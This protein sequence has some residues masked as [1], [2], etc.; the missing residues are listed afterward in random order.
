MAR[1]IAIRRL[2]EDYQ[3]VERDYYRKT[4]IFPPMHIIAIRRDVY[5]RNRWVAQSLCKAFI[6]AQ[7]EVYGE[8]HET[9]ALM[10]ML[11]WLTS[12]VEE[13]EKLMGRDFWPYGYEPNIHALQHLPSIS[14]RTGSFEAPV[15][16][17]GDFR[18][19]VAR[20][21]QDLTPKWWSLSRGDIDTALVQVGFNLAQMVIPVFLLLPRGNPGRVPAW[22]TFC[23]GMRWDS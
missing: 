21:F 20:G 8:L 17:E 6:A 12:H 2:F 5:E 3:S 14:P 4:R 23:R 7:A 9:G 11:P 18:A 10:H 22:R 16:A 15:D 19:G 1:A 13:T